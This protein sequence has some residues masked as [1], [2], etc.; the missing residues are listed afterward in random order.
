[1][2]KLAIITT[3]PIQY[4]A[5]LFEMLSQREIIKIKVFYTWGADVIEDKYDPGFKKNINWDI[6]LLNGYEYQFVENIAKNPGSH[7][8][9]GIINPTLISEI[10]KW[11][12][13]GI[14]VFG[15]KFKSHLKCLKYFS[16]K[17]TI[18]FRGDST[19]L[20]DT[21]KGIKSIIKDLI[22]RSVYK[23]VDYCLYVGNANK[24]Y[25]LKYG[26][27]ENHLIFAPHA[28][29]N[30]RFS[31]KKEKSL[32]EELSLN[33]NDFVFLFAG[34]LETKKNPLLLLNSFI[35][36]NIP[37][38]Y[39]LF[40]GNGELELEIKNI[41]SLLEQSIRN[42][43]LIID[44]QNQQRMPLV[45]KTANVF[46]LP[47]Q[48]PGETWGL[49]VNEAMAS[50]VPV[51]VSD[52]CGCYC[53]LIEDYKNGFVFESNN[54]TSLK[55]AMKYMAEHIEKSNLMGKNAVTF[56]S[57]WSYERICTSIE[58]TL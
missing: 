28:I 5:P 41:C 38:T 49:S 37:N 20:D 1:L 55:S 40:V 42:R 44:F 23:N 16:K 54:S 35:E 3:H 46:I 34:K 48:G 9:N 32:R 52:K 53:D 43:I 17:L 18:I 11:Q 22:L 56:I 12:A 47:S 25:F 50:G 7:H 21:Q 30:L 33:Q 39:L 13:D 2:R 36:L 15:W 57:N 45:Y 51:I 10:K 8:Y 58:S 19:L 4:N 14:L 29:D 31:I 6:P 24:K 27:K 26:V